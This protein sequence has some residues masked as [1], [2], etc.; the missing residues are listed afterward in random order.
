MEMADNGNVIVI[1]YQTP[2][3]KSSS[4]GGLNQRAVLNTLNSAVPREVYN[5]VQGHVVL[6]WRKNLTVP[7]TV[8]G[9]SVP[10]E[11]QMVVLFFFCDFL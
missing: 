4:R 2:E 1:L 9:R 6:Y 8:D 10:A 7:L 3:V 11:K 5:L